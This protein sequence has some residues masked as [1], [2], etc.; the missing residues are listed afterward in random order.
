MEMDSSDRAV[1]WDSMA[2]LMPGTIDFTRCAVLLSPS[3]LVAPE[4]PEKRINKLSYSRL[5]SDLMGDTNIN[6]KMLIT[7]LVQ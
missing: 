4:A 6:L 1:S 7:G 5:L 3:L 2:T